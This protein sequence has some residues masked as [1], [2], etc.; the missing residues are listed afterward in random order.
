MAADPC[1]G[2][3][4]DAFLKQDFNST[5]LVEHE[6]DGS[7]CGFVGIEQMLESDAFALTGDFPD[8]HLLEAL[9]GRDNAAHGPPAHPSETTAARSDSSTNTPDQHIPASSQAGAMSSIGD[10][11]DSGDANSDLPSEKDAADLHRDDLTALEQSYDW[12]TAIAAQ[13]NELRNEYEV[14]PHFQLRFG[15]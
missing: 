1:L 6:T 13:L 2:F 14:F 7:K 10:V 15:R 4:W 3:D 9:P 11:P 5:F 8:V 12:S